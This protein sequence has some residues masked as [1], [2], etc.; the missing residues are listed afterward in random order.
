[1]NMI[2]QQTLCYLASGNN[3]YGNL[4]IDKSQMSQ[5]KFKD[6]NYD[7]EHIYLGNKHAIGIWKNGTMYTWGDNTYY[8][9][10]FME[11]V[12]KPSEVKFFTYSGIKIVQA[13]GGD[14]HTIALDSNGNVWTW[15]S[16]SNGQLGRTD[17][18][19]GQF[20][21]NPAQL[22]SYMFGGEK[23]MFVAAQDLITLVRTASGK[24]Y[25][26]GLC[27]K[28]LCDVTSNKAITTP[29]LLNVS[30]NAS[31]LFVGS[32]NIFVEDSQGFVYV[33]G[34]NDYGQLCFAPE[35]SDTND[36]SGYYQKQFKVIQKGGFEKIALGLA[37]SVMMSNN[38][39]YG[40]GALFNA[41]FEQVRDAGKILDIAVSAHG[42]LVLEK[43][44][45]YV[46]G[47]DTSGELGLGGQNLVSDGQILK[48]KNY[49]KIISR[50]DFSFIY[51]HSGLS[52]GA[53]TAIVI[54]SVVGV[55]AIVAAVVFGIY[56][57]KKKGSNY[58]QIGEKEEKE[59]MNKPDEW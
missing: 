3:K 49:K 37:H 51:K 10:G 23:V 1:M 7:F 16:N 11:Y 15:G 57:Y 46:K 34:K 13:D 48:L 35:E 54:G 58:K 44:Q 43:K 45:V 18:P 19:I 22:P 29:T 42:F 32:Q 25:I 40:C 55:V 26:F 24:V 28:F 14:K 38:V 21:Y 2:L 36:Q 30:V 59:M 47:T 20:T 4:G 33:R 6:I 27:T 8:Q 50:N 31:R 5:F 56:V 41:P 17:V 12:S 53:I 39:A 52:A 9:L